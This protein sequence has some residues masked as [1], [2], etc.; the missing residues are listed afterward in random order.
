MRRSPSVARFLLIHFL[1]KIG[2]RVADGSEERELREVGEHVVGGSPTESRWNGLASTIGGEA[3]VVVG[4]VVRQGH[5][6]LGDAVGGVVA[7]AVDADEALSGGISSELEAKRFLPDGGDHKLLEDFTKSAAVVLGVITRL[8]LATKGVELRPITVRVGSDEGEH[9]DLRLVSASEP[10]L[11][12]MVVSGVKSRRD[13][14][15]AGGGH[16]LYDEGVR[17]V[18]H[19]GGDRLVAET[20]EGVGG[21]FGGRE[22]TLGEPSG[23]ETSR[24]GNLAGIQ[25]A[26]TFEA[27][28]VR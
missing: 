28:I 16:G 19:S 14:P 18:E 10:H 23:L 9:L 11:G 25:P 5:E 4:D 12:G 22:V 24:G 7:S 3:R 17:L 13:R 8:H 6:P 1:K 26:T 21:Q 27:S 20:S 15:G 2:E